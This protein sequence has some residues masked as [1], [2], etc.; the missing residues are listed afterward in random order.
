MRIRP[1]FTIDYTNLVEVAKQKGLTVEE[2]R[3]IIRAPTVVVAGLLAGT[4]DLSAEGVLLEPD[5]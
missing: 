2:L 1:T 3:S 5:Q 4:C